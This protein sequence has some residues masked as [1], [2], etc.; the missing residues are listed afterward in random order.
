[1][2]EFDPKEV[3]TIVDGIALTGYSE[4][5][6]VAAERMEDTFTEYVGA[7]G[8]VSTSENANKT[9][10]ITVTL[11]STSPSV[12]YLNDLANRGKV[13]PVQ[14]IDMNDSSIVSGSE[15]R[16]RKPANYQAGK[17]IDEREFVIF[18]SELDFD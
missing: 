9:G 14:I 5:S 4:N 12:R 18:V 8:E 3:N 13:F 15:A 1:M 2:R 11:Q 17:E 6:M 7:K 16:V 10:E